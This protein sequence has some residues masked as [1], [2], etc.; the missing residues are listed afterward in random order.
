MNTLARCS[1]VARPEW[2]AI[3]QNIR[4]D[5]PIRR[6][7]YAWAVLTAELKPGMVVLDAGAGT[8]D[9]PRYLQE[10]CGCDVHVADLF[11]EGVRAAGWGNE[12]SERAI[13]GITYTAA[14][15]RVLPYPNGYFDRVLCIS[16]LEHLSTP[17]G[18]QQLNTLHELVRVV[19]DGG[20]L[21][22]CADYA[23]NALVLKGAR[24]GRYLWLIG[25]LCDSESEVGKYDCRLHGVTVL[26]ER[27][28]DHFLWGWA[29]KEGSRVWD[30]SFAF[31]LQKRAV[32]WQDT[33][34]GR[35]LEPYLSPM[36]RAALVE[37]RHVIS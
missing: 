7:E 17:D 11:G 35:Q 36:E 9:L 14:D 26:D 34:D 12:Q 23:D 20:L 8:S 15:L 3:W 37:G 27:N 2:Q 5:F 28:P 1:D 10:V 24:L 33:T 25:K 31:A 18:Q 16:V 4:C 13:P 30:G 22:V 19:K 6:W 21:L 32:Q 29:T